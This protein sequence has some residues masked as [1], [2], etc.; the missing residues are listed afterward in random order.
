MSNNDCSSKK[1]Q[2]IP[3]LKSSTSEFRDE[4]RLSVAELVN[5]FETL[6]P[7]NGTQGIIPKGGRHQLS[8]HRQ[9]IVKRVSTGENGNWDDKRLYNFDSGCE[10]SPKCGTAKIF[11]YYKSF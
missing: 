9:Q 10:K 8:G 11:V 3:K 7:D 6:K 2:T 4:R 5:K 1:Q